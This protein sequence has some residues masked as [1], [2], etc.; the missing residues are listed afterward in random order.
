MCIFLQGK[1]IH[2]MSLGRR[3]FRPTESQMEYLITRNKEQDWPGSSLGGNVWSHLR[4]STQMTLM[5]VS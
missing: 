2:L 3:P 4:L 1:K 5:S